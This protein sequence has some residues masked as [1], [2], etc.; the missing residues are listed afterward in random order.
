MKLLVT[1]LPGARTVAIHVHD[2]CTIADVKQAAE[3]ATGVASDLQRLL[4]R[5]R[6]RRDHE[7]LWDLGIRE[8]A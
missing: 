8:G 3:P 6:E 5:G 4:F 2:T 1:C 7:A